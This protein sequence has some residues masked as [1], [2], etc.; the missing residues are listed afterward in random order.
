MGQ[1]RAERVALAHAAGDI[2]GGDF[3]VIVGGQAQAFLLENTPDAAMV[4]QRSVMDE[5]L[6]A[7]SGEGMGAI[8]CHG[9]FCGHAGVADAVGASHRFQPEAPR[10]HRRQADFLVKLHARARANDCDF[11]GKAGDDQPSIGLAF[12][13]NAEN[14]VGITGYMGDF[15]AKRRFDL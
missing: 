5:A 1:R 4:R 13:R 12:G 3:A 7:A 2:G 10:D 6:V 15:A 9:A 14:T 11:R 8:R